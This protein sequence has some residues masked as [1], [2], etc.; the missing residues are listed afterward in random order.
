MR[1]IYKKIE[2]KHGDTRIVSKFLWFPVTIGDETRKWERTMI[3]QTYIRRGW[4]EFTNYGW[5]NEKFIDNIIKS[6][7]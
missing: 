5:C 3:L 1:Y 2:P 7:K 4:G 6:D